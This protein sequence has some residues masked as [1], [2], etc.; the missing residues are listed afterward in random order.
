MAT[1]TRAACTISI[2]DSAVKQLTACAGRGDVEATSILLKSIH[3]TSENAWLKEPMIAASKA[4]SLH[5]VML[6][7][8]Y[9]ASRGEPEGYMG[10]FPY[11]SE[12][13][14]AARAAGHREIANWLESSY[15]FTPLQH[16]QVLTPERTVTLLRDS[17]T[18]PCRGRPSPLQLARQNPTCAAAPFVLRASAAWSPATH[19]MWPGPQRKRAAELCRIG[20][21]LARRKSAHAGSFLDAF[22]WHVIPHAV[23]HDA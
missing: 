10:C 22:I 20:Q 7:S 17:E 8:S 18:S 21:L 13:E 14:S 23:T 15:G 1:M 19:S 16:L 11:G 12:A 4:G 2:E 5:V 3:A 6:L 9:G